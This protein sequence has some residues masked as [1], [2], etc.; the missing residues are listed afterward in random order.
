MELQKINNNDIHLTLQFNGNL[1]ADGTRNIQPVIDDIIWAEPH[2]EVE[3]DFSD[4]RFMDSSGVGALVYLYKR[5]VEKKRNMRLE[6]VS[7]QPLEIIHLLRISKT[8]AVNSR[9]H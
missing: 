3:L 1:D 4:V 9:T 6:N 2:R 7:G 5:L 8:I